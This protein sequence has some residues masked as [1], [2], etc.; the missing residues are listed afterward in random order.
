MPEPRPPRRD[1]LAPV[2]IEMTLKLLDSV[3]HALVAAGAGRPIHGTDAPPIR[4]ACHRLG[5]ILAAL[6]E[7]A[8]S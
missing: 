8:E 4:A 2:E 6:A 1:P 3:R 7:K 5:A